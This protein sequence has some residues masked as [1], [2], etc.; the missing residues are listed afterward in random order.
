MPRYTLETIVVV[1][2]VLWLLGAFI[3]PVAGVGNLIHVL[4]LVALVVV[5]IRLVQGRRLMD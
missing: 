2:L 1:L 3:S 5:V 4:L